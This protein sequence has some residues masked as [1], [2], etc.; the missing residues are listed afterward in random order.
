MGCAVVGGMIFSDWKRERDRDEEMKLRCLDYW[1]ALDSIARVN[2]ERFDSIVGDE[3]SKSRN[4]ENSKENLAGAVDEKSSR[5]IL[6][7]SGSL[8]DIKSEN[9]REEDDEV[10]E[11]KHPGTP[12]DDGMFGFDYWDDEDDAYEMDRNQQDAYPDDW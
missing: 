4:L 7:A 8:N 5:E 11:R 1:E 2:P 6:R 9:N 12:P 3:N 10:D